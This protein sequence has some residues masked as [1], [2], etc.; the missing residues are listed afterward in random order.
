MNYRHLA[1]DDGE[2]WHASVSLNWPGYG[3]SS[4]PCGPHDERYLDVSGLTAEPDD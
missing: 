2:T 1:V 4:D 3:L